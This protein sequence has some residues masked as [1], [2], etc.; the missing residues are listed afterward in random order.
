METVWGGAG[1]KILSGNYNS[2]RGV[3]SFVAGELGYGV[4]GVLGS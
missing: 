1:S 4:G 3:L 2:A